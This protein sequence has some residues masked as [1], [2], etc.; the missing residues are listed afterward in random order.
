MTGTTL[1]ERLRALS[2]CCHSG[3]YLANRP[4]TYEVAAALLER[5]DDTTLVKLTPDSA[6]SSRSVQARTVAVR[7]RRRNSA[8]SPKPSP[9]PRVATPSAP[10]PTSAVPS[11]MT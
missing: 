10:F 7:G 2:G 3:E 4:S 9:A 6:I 5:Y 8:I 11:T 1:L